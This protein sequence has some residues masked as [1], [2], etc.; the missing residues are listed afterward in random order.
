MRTDS[1]RMNAEDVPAAEAERAHHGDLG[2]ALA[3]RHG[4]RVRD[5]QRDREEDDRA[6]CR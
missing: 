1:D 6:R 5:D 3:R 2:H 4:D